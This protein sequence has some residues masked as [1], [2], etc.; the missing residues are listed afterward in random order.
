MANF[1]GLCVCAGTDL[2]QGIT[3]KMSEFRNNEA[4]TGHRTKAMALTLHWTL[5][6]V[7]GNTTSRAFTVIDSAQ[8]DGTE[9]A[10]AETN[11]KDSQYA[12]GQSTEPKTLPSNDDSADST[13]RPSVSIPPKPSLSSGAGEVDANDGGGLSTGAIAGI[14]VGVGVLALVVL[15]AVI[16]F[17]MRRR[18]RRQ[19]AEKDSYDQQAKMSYMAAGK[20]ASGNTADSPMSPYRDDQFPPQQQQQ[21]QHYVP[22]RVPVPA[23][24]AERSNSWGT[25]GANARSPTPGSGAATPQHGVSRHLVEEGMSADEIRR[26]EEEER[27]L[28]DEIQRAGK[29]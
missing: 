12:D 15:G 28:D 16:F 21:Q 11:L 5:G 10:E 29:R 9:R 18:R 2:T 22:P 7:I 25:D 20:E 19:S 24:T 1:P 4:L 3:L 14:A 6:E 17:C 13:S 27:Q 23:T 8:G 26:L